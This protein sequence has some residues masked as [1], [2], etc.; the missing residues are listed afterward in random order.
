MWEFQKSKF[1]QKKTKVSRSVIPKSV[2]LSQLTANL[3]N[4]A[5]IVS[6]FLIKDTD[7]IGRSIQDVIVEP[8]RKHLIP[9]FTK[10]K[11]NAL[12]AGALGV[13]ISGAG[14]SVIAFSKKSHNL[15]KIAKA[16]K[17]GFRS[18]K[19]DCDIVICKPSNGPKIRI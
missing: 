9:G 4:A 7:L 6:G 10:V 14:P 17:D 2:K 3:S 8:A 11:N 13:T 19:V 16:M 15:K 18:A 1:L 5:G 12:K